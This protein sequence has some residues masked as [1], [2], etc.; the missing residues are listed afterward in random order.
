MKVVQGRPI[1]SGKHSDK[2]NTADSHPDTAQPG[3]PDPIQFNV[4]G[5]IKTP[6]IADTI[7]ARLERIEAPP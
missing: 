5:H 6:M 4:P 1:A 3:D 2:Q 7:K